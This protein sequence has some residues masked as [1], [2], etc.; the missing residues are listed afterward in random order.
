MRIVK[1][2][3]ERRNEILDAAEAL[4]GEKGFAATS[5][6]DILERIG[7]ARGTLYYHF[8]SKAAIMEALVDRLAE[9]L[10]RVARETAQATR[11]LPALDRLLATVAAFKLGGGAEAGV[12]EHLHEPGNVLLHRRVQRAIVGGVTSILADIARDGV[13]EGSF[14]TPF[15]QE[16]MELVVVYIT[17]VIDG[18]LVELSDEDRAARARALVF[19]LGRLFGLS[20][21]DLG[22]VLSMFAGPE[23]G[24]EAGPEAG[25]AAGRRG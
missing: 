3:E 10:F 5:T 24:P 6:G 14:D 12:M 9:R 7:I 20:E 2:A 1:E 4:F 19:N 16:S 25:P 21:K 18:D 23:S 22:R 11:D 13:K 15:P 17:E 8:E